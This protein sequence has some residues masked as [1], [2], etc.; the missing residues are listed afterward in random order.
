MVQPSTYWLVGQ[1]AKVLSRIHGFPIPE[2]TVRARTFEGRGYSRL[3]ESFIVPGT[4]ILAIPDKA[5]Q[6][7]IEWW[8]PVQRSGSKEPKHPTGEDRWLTIAG[9][10]DYLQET[11]NDTYRWILEENV[12]PHTKHRGYPFVKESDLDAFIRKRLEGDIIDGTNTTD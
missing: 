12:I 6:E 10:A 11:R 2:N 9:A 7:F 3:L 1:A 8:T 5:F 4:H